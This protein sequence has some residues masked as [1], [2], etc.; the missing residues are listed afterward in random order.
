[1]HPTA[2]K[3]PSVLLSGKNHPSAVWVRENRSNYQW[4]YQLLDN[5]LVEY[6][7]RYGKVHKT[8]SSGIFQNLSK[9]PYEL[10]GGKF[11]EPPQCMPDDCKDDDPVVA[12]RNS[13]VREKSYMARWKNT[14]S[15]AW[16]KIGTAIEL[17]ETA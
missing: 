2:E 16:Y 5:L 10:P 13:Y 7:F 15:P 1:M 4:L 11:T 14:D 12:Y 17:M 9:I 3:L 6:T 8:E